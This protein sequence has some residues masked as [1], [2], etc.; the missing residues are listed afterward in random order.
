[1]FY[2]ALFEVPNPEHRLRISMTAQVSIVLSNAR[3]ALSIP[4]AALG[5]KRKDGTYAV[6]VLRAD[7]STETRNV[8]IGINNNVR[9]EVLAGLKDG[10]RVVIGDAAGDDHAPLADVV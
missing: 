2:N 10:E 9:V 1:V 8:R 6:R 3:N 5:E 4:A 7:G